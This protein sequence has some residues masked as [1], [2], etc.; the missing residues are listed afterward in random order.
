[1]NYAIRYFFSVTI[2]CFLPNIYAEQVITLFLKQYPIISVDQ[3]AQ[4]LAQK[5]HKPGKIATNQVKN[6]FSPSQLSGI[7]ATYGGYLIASDVNGEISFPR[8]HS[9]PVIYLI[10]TE[11]LIP[12]V[13]S[14]NT[15][16]HWELDP[17][18]PA[19]MY[20]YEQHVDP[21]THLHYWQVT[22]VPVPADHIIP[23]ESIAIM[24]NPKYVYVPQG[25][26]VFKE[27]PHLVLPDIYIKKGINLTTQALYM[28]NL[29]HYFGPII[30]LHKKEK[31]GYSRH[32]TY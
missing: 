6:Y 27:T 8:R 1:M 18:M 31:L 17:S 12:I 24:A 26:T 15:I 9:K 2:F 32:L 23:L 13:M 16:H 22:Q 21:D 3:A 28:L 4:K 7:F 20:K 14:G 5:L 25:I 11:H 10:I 19:H 30:P 29:S